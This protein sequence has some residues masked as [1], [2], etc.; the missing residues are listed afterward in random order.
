M[1]SDYQAFKFYIELILNVLCFVFNR[2]SSFY[3]FNDLTTLIIIL[4]RGFMQRSLYLE[5]PKFL[6]RNLS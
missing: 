3:L 2:Q 6:L 4:Q 5:A 1:L